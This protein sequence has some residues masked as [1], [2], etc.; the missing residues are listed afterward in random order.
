MKQRPVL[1]AEL[2]PHTVANEEEGGEFTAE[3]IGLSKFM[4]Y[5]THIV[6]TSGR[7]EAEGR[8]LLLQGVSLVL[9]CLPWAEARC[10][11]NLAM[12]KVEQGR[13]DWT[14]DFKALAREYVDN[15]V[16][17]NLR[18][19]V[20]S[21]S[22]SSSSRSNTGSRGT[23]RSYG[24]GSY[25]NRGNNFYRNSNVQYNVCKQWN[26]GECTFAECKRWHCCWTCY[27]QGKK[28]QQHKA[29]THNNANNTNVRGRQSGQNT[30][31]V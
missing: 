29:L 22:A 9:Q 7:A 30:Q 11:H 8:S 24:N 28:G 16:R 20:P 21:A 12:L 23:G 14:T 4:F 5:F 15:K 17:L 2:W 25:A 18:Y 26:Y 27:E 31:Q 13:E 6:N 19:Q 1:K 3:N 10:F